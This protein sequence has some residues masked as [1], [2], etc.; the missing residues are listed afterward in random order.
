[1]ADGPTGMKVSETPISRIILMM[2]SVENDARWIG[3]VAI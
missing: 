2:Q 3:K 1:M